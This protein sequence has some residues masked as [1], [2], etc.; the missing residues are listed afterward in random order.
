MSVVPPHQGCE[1]WCVH[2][3]LNALS[4]GK[5]CPTGSVMASRWVRCPPSTRADDSENRW[6]PWGSHSADWAEGRRYTTEQDAFR[7]RQWSS[8]RSGR[9]GVP[10]RMQPSRDT[11]L[12]RKNKRSDVVHAPCLL[13]GQV[14][15]AAKAEAIRGR[16][17]RITHATNATQRI[18][19]K[20]S[21]EGWSW[22]SPSRG[23]WRPWL[24]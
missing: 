23:C 9:R 10:K 18:P 12:N 6:F 1:R 16:P 20:K 3:L 17:R 22:T 14:P 15:P 2:S 5:D 11:D 24:C 7:K 8:C 4:L 13:R 21:E 19:P